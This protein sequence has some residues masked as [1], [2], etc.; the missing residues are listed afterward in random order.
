MSEKLTYTKAIAELE[1]IV[2]QIESEE[3]LVEELLIKV[4]R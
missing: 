2:K 1:E 4:K 3:V